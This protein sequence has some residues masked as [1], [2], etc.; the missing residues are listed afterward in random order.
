MSYSSSGYEGT[1]GDI[2]Y[3]GFPVHLN[4]FSSLPDP[5]IIV[6]PTL[7]ITFKSLLKK[8]PITKQKSLNDLI[9]LSKTEK[10]SSFQDDLTIITWIQLYPKLAIENSRAIRLASHQV[11]A[12]FLQLVGGKNFSKYLKSSLP[13]WLSGIFDSEKAVATATYKSLLDS[14]QNDRDKVDEK[15]WIIFYEQIINYIKTTISIETPKSLSDSRFT[16]EEDSVVKYQRVLQNSLQMLIRVI[17]LINS[18]GIP[19]QS[20]DFDIIAEIISSE[21]LWN[22]LGEALDES[23]MNYSLFGTLLELLKTI[24]VG[25]SDGELSVF[26][27]NLTDI[28]SI[29]KTVSK[30]FIKLVKLKNNKS[31]PTGN[32]VYSSFI[33][34]FWDTLRAL[35]LFSGLKNIKSVKVKKNFWE[36]GGS[37][38]FARLVEYLKL[39][40]CQSNPAYYTIISHFISSL[41]SSEININED[42]QFVE[43]H[44]FGSATLLIGKILNKQYKSLS[45]FDYKEKAIQCILSVYDIFSERLDDQLLPLLKQILY[46][47]IDSVS[48]DVLRRDA[49]P[50]K[51]S[52][53]VAISQSV[54]QKVANENMSNFF[55]DFDNALSH[56]VQNNESKLS[57]DGFEF[58][59]NVSKIVQSYFDILLLGNHFD[60]AS[61]VVG[62]TVDILVEDTT[63]EKPVIAFNIISTYLGSFRDVTEKTQLVPLLEILPSFFEQDFVKEP[64]E[65]LKS[66]V[67]SNLQQ[68]LIEE[69][70][71]GSYLKLTMVAPE[72]NVSL[73]RTL[74]QFIDFETKKDTYP[75]IYEYLVELSRK[76]TLTPEESNLIYS[77]LNV[78][79]V[80]ENLVNV[81]SEDKGR[82]HDF[83]KAIA[84][85]ASINTLTKHFESESLKTIARHAWEN[86]HDPDMAKFFDWIKID[87]SF[88]ELS[89]YN[90][91]ESCGFQT[92]FSNIA[93]YLDNDFVSFDLLETRVNNAMSQIPNHLISISNPLENNV[94]LR[95][96][97]MDLVLDRGIITFGK[98][99]NTILKSTKGE[100][101]RLYVLGS[102][103][104][105]Y[106]NDLLVLERV[107]ER[108]HSDEYLQIRESLMSCLLNIFKESN[109][110][111]TR[112]VS[113]NQIEG[114]S[115]DA[116]VLNHLNS[117]MNGSG[118]NWAYSARVFKRILDMKFE[119]MSLNTFEELTI[120]YRVLLKTPIKFAAF[121]L[122]TTKFFSSAKFDRIRNFVVAE[123][124]GVRK[125][126]EILTE[127]LKWI[128]LSVNFFNVEERSD[129]V[130][131]HRLAMI[132]N[133]IFNWLESGVAYDEEFVSM[134]VL[135]TKFFSGLIVKQSDLPDKAWEVISRLLSDN[136]STCENEPSRIDLKYF[137]LK[138]LD[139][140]RKNGKERYPEEWKEVANSTRE[141]ILDL[142][143]NTDI[144]SAD[145]QYNNQVIVQCNE[146]FVRVVLDYDI[147]V[148]MLKAHEN[149]LYNILSG[150]FSI[151]LKRVAVFFLRKIIL[152]DQQDF[153][154]EYQ[155]KKSKLEQTEVEGELEVNLPSA[156]INIIQKSLEYDV[157][158]DGLVAT[159]NWGWYLVFAYLEDITYSLRTEYIKLLKDNGSLDHLLI[160][161]FE[162]ADVTDNK[163]LKKL[164][165]DEIEKSTKVHNSFISDYDIRSGIPGESFAFEMQFLLLHHY[166]LSLKYISSPVQ[167]WYKEIR[168]KQ[169]KQRVEKFTTKFVS[170]LLVAQILN[171]VG[172]A[173]DKL[174]SRD[175]NLT[176]KVN[177]ITN[178]IRS[179]YV[180]DEQTMEMVVKIPHNY[181]LESVTVEGPLRLGV[182]EIQWKAWLL[183]SQRV[184]S[185]TNGSIV[186]AIELFNKNVN[187]HF[188][189]FEECA[190]CYSILHQ[191]LSLPSK[192]CSTCNNKFHAACLYKW[193]KSSG[194]STC[195]LCRSTFTFRAGRS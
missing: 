195:P 146:L 60:I 78:S 27:K 52:I 126:S 72:Q 105:E 57:V 64:L 120:D 55:G 99:I 122:S 153:V 17:K 18:G 177:K 61:A 40:S 174:E 173:K 180:I 142:F 45:S 107:T 58:S 32:I 77:Q 190:I 11:Q 147:P 15:I 2:G 117:G 54:G 24:F 25:N 44:D 22:Y 66:F 169:L 114:S 188:S 12:I 70:V 136:L 162:R 33:L 80:F 71:N 168:D 138:L 13:V 133:Q 176:V 28:K 5:S 36:L 63:I 135:L 183:A 26:A 159:F 140:V 108:V 68:S 154:L 106:I 51:K 185:L 172:E 65:L 29:Y 21:K 115:L 9:S 128:S 7:G 89:L 166:F 156:L 170:P 49:I 102:L 134:R 62:N 145:I 143:T 41:A 171:D 158:D 125:E 123:I 141:E 179:V 144:I 119:S 161:I 14:F 83:V 189:G 30:K 157:D 50:K 181:P 74:S 109:T 184:I 3:N 113:D 16:K 4:Y 164:S 121:Q 10:S 127:G 111:I 81:S 88:F 76:K 148:K 97:K 152:A 112:L 6:D 75:E 56:L 67:T 160:H 96:S 59:S 39:G 19:I 182:K 116:K 110:D 87:R 167:T 35:T 193:F 1:S 91:V 53:E 86:I 98:F 132:C 175:E 73:L 178:E 48:V 130:P 191:D 8:D 46:M 100:D 155:L 187:L 38:S 37:K 43:F 85:L 92:D 47:T 151:P 192:S 104:S 90:Y 101:E 69:A 42:F 20:V 34:Q 163:F 93:K 137:S 186:D 79:E 131:P 23:T 94:Y 129:V 194:S 124:L 31:T 103:I 82:S 95:D 118:S 149:E 84:N 139:V 150:E 165:P